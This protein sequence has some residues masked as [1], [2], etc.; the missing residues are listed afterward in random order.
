MDEEICACAGG[1]KELNRRSL[2]DKE[3]WISTGRT[4]R[5]EL[6]RM[7]EKVVTARVAIGADVLRGLM[8]GEL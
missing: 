6:E 1:S 2:Q 7:A 8:T 3:K 5:Q 4:G